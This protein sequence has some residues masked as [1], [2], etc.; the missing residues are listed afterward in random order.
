[1]GDYRNVTLFG[2]MEQESTWRIVYK[3]G[4][5]LYPS[6][7][8]VTSTNIDGET[9]GMSYNIL[10]TW[11][12]VGAEIITFDMVNNITQGVSLYYSLTR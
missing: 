11:T 8:G 6:S 12:D 9:S 7:N 3:Y 1:M 10:N 5:E 4:G 2:S